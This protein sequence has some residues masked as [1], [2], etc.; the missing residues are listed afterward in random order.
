M[1]NKPKSKSLT[2]ADVAKACGR[3]D[4]DCIEGD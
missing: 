2:L 1:E 4:D 3:L